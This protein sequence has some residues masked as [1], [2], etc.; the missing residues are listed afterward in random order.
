MKVVVMATALEAGVVTPSD[1]FDTFNGHLVL[2]KR[3]IGEAENQRTGWLTAT[4]G[5][6]Y[7]CN[8]VLAQIGLRIPKERFHQTFLDL[9]YSRYPGS[10]LG[11]ERRGLVPPLPWRNPNYEQASVSFGH[12]LSVSL[13]QHAA[14]LATVLRGGEYR[15]LTLI[16]PVE[17]HGLPPTPPL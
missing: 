3:V 16:Q 15:P 14:G 5:L 1:R 17:R 6:A 12:E 13:W 2:G 8:A 7:S 10:G 4:E 9:G 11:S